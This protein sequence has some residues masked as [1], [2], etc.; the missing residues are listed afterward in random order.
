MDDFEKVSSGE[1]HEIYVELP[2]SAE[3]I[4]AIIYGKADMVAGKDFSSEEGGLPEG[5]RL[6]DIGVDHEKHAVADI[7]NGLRGAGLT[8]SQ[9]HGFIGL[10]L[11]LLKIATEV[12]TT[13]LFK[14]GVELVSLNKDLSP[15]ARLGLEVSS[16][17][18]NAIDQIENGAENCLKELLDCFGLKAIQLNPD[19][20]RQKYIGNIIFEAHTT[21][22]EVVELDDFRK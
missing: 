2:I 12:Y 6:Q 4:V 3:D 21:V 10:N 9:S 19:W 15:A 22:A 13:E 17:N 1:R 20:V 5:W 11:D 14:D 16:S 18:G 8:E 7:Y